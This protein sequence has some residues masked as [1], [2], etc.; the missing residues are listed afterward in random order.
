MNEVGMDGPEHKWKELLCELV[1]D[2]IWEIKARGKND[3]KINT[4]FALE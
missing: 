4:K 1:K 2:L 3:S